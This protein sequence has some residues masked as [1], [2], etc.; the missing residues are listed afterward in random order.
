MWARN[1]DPVGVRPHGKPVTVN[2]QPCEQVV[3]TGLANT[4]LNA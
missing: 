1:A 3:P 4:L 2:Q